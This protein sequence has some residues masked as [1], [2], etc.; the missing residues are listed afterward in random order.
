MLAGN[1]TR[2]VMATAGWSTDMLA[3]YYRRDNLQTAKRLRFHGPEGA[4][5]KVV[6]EG[7]EQRTAENC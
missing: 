3:V 4:G 1:D 5:V 7:S 6:C 2:A